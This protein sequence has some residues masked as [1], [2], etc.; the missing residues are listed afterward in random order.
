MTYKYLNRPFI[1]GILFTL[2]VAV[3]SIALAG[4]PVISSIGA[5]DRSVNWRVYGRYSD[6]LSLTSGHYFLPKLLRFAIVLYGFKLNLQLISND[7]W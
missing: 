5:L 3:I 4:L 2:A 1:F 7:G 6:T